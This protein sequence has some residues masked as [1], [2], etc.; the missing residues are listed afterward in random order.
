MTKVWWLEGTGCGTQGPGQLLHQGPSVRYQC[1]GSW[2]IILF[3]DFQLQ[4]NQR[5]HCGLNEGCNPARRWHGGVWCP[6]KVFPSVIGLKVWLNY[7]NLII[8]FS[9]SL[10]YLWSR[11][12]GIWCRSCSMS[13]SCVCR[14][15]PRRGESSCWRFLSRISNSRSCRDSRFT[16]H[17]VIIASLLVNTHNTRLTKDIM[18]SLSWV[19]VWAQF[20]LPYLVYSLYALSAEL[21]LPVDLSIYRTLLLASWWILNQWETMF[22]SQIQIWIAAKSG[23]KY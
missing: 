23:T 11:S 21:H 10:L 22:Y 8:F 16:I 15:G 18:S 4:H 17:Q 12:A 13:S 5:E 7:D 20:P 1:P 6:G 3:I 2:S 14:P 19:M 9:W